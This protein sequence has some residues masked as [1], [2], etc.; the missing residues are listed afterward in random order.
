ML[1]KEYIKQHLIRPDGRFSGMR[2]KA[3]GIDPEEGLTTQRKACAATVA[4]VHLLLAL[5]RVINRFAAGA[6]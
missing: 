3:L 1:T 6:A 5:P 2:A 4:Q